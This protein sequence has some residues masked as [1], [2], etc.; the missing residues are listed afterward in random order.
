M[1]G[2]GTSLDEFAAKALLEHQ[3][4][5]FSVT[6]DFPLVSELLKDAPAQYGHRSVWLT[7]NKIEG[8]N[9]CGPNPGKP[10]IDVAPNVDDLKAAIQVAEILVSKSTDNV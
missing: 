2:S 4:A 7:V 1:K 9:V 6:K 10:M 8:C 3:Y 5:I